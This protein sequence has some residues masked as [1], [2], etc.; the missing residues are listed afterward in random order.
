M[1]TGWPTLMKT[2]MMP[3]L[4]RSFFLQRDHELPNRSSPEE[5]EEERD[6]RKTEK[7]QKKK[8]KKKKK[9]MRKQ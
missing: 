6:E 2:M 1:K 5:G 4:P 9:I 8:M 3:T 7:I